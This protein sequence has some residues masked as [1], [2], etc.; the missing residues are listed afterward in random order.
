MSHNIKN[1]SFV[2]LIIIF[3][4]GACSNKA[5]PY[6]LNCCNLPNDTINF[7][8]FTR[9][10]EPNWILQKSKIDSTNNLI[11]SLNIEPTVSR[12]NNIT[13]KF[14]W[15][16]GGIIK[17]QRINDWVFMERRF[18]HV[19]YIFNNCEGASEFTRTKMIYPKDT[20]KQSL[21]YYRNF[22]PHKLFIRIMI[23]GQP[24]NTYMQA[25]S[26][27]YAKDDAW[28]SIEQFRNEI[29]I[30]GPRHYN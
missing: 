2:L 15:H 5:E 1:T 10:N 9:I 6:T 23:Q 27:K 21:F 4:A 30:F 26:N 16:N 28:S 7:E 25:D 14:W 13:R 8:Q 18:N 19:Y 12:F 22:E 24:S 29:K 20:I 17:I 3:I 11:T